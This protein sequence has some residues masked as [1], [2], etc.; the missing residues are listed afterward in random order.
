MIRFVTPG[1]D[2]GPVEPGEPGGRDP[3]MV[4]VYVFV[5][6]CAAIAGGI[7]MAGAP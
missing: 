1:W 3:I 7:V 6:V 4:A 5:A 2:D